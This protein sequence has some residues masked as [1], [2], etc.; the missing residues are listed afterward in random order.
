[1]IFYFFT[2]L[3]FYLSKFLCKSFVNCLIYGN[4]APDFHK[5]NRKNS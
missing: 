3:L 4:F 5:N 2:F 1:M